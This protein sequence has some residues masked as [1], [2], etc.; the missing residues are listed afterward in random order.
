MKLTNTDTSCSRNTTAT[1]TTLEEQEEESTRLVDA[2]P[3]INNTSEMKSM[4]T[5]Q[6]VT[7]IVVTKTQCKILAVGFV[8]LFVA[9]IWIDYSFL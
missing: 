8:L 3:L 5:T 9:N 4:H 7:P 2:I 6:V 1:S